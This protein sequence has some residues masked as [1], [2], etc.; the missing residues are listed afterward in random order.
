[1][2]ESLLDRDAVIYHE[3]MAHTPLFAH[4]KPQNVAIINDCDQGI[5]AEVLKH[6]SVKQIWH[7]ASKQI[8]QKKDDTRITYCDDKKFEP[9]SLD[10]III[11]DKP[12]MDFHR[13]FT[14][15]HADGI[16][17]QLCESPFQL[18]NLITIRRE[19]KAAG[20]HDI[21]LLQFPQPSFTSGWRSAIMAIKNGTIR[22]P[23]EKDIFNKS[24]ATQYYNL[25]VHRAAF[26]LPEFMRLE[27]EI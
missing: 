15:L 11:A 24:F 8:S 19:M 16:L 6:S 20:F 13:Y 10:A 23:R 9:A 3:M 27:W 25:D 18:A 17:I 26:A 2:S 22:R 1:M 7:L 14:N 4:R 12:E 5:V 21:Q